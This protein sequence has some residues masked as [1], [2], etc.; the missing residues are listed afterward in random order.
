MKGQYKNGKIT[1]YTQMVNYLRGG[2]WTTGWSG[3]GTTDADD[4]EYDI[5]NPENI[6]LIDGNYYDF[7]LEDEIAIIKNI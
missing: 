3:I 7:Y 4:I 2:S 1:Y 6:E 5:F